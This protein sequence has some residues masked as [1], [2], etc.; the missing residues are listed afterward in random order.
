MGQHHVRHQWRRPQS[1]FV[2]TSKNRTVYGVDVVCQAKRVMTLH[3]QR[4]QTFCFADWPGI[5]IAIPWHATLSHRLP[6]FR[7]RVVFSRNYSR[8]SLGLLRWRTNVPSKRWETITQ[9]R[10]LVCQKS[11]QEGTCRR[12]EIACCFH[13][14]GTRLK[15]ETAAPIIFVP[16]HRT[17]RLHIPEDC[18]LHIRRCENQ[19]FHVRSVLFF[20]C[21]T[22]SSSSQDS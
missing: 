11:P 12:L 8:V 3:S 2:T 5:N 19:R 16:L 10:T 20:F 13:L 7:H 6:T 21:R 1:D 4:S 15:T 18:D 17:T 14:Q 9:W 22:K